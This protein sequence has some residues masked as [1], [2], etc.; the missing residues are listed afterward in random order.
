MDHWRYLIVRLNPSYFAFIS[1]I[2]VSAATNLLTDLATTKKTELGLN[3]PGFSAALLLFG[4]GIFFILLSWNLEE[5]F[6]KWKTIGRDLGWSEQKILEI[7]ANGKSKQLWGLMILGILL[8]I[9]GLA[10]LFV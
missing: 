9:T 3:L 8:F 6:R 2:S 7:S 10:I 4:A 5:P 1:G